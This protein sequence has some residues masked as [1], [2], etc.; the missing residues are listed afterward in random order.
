[1]N[2]SPSFIFDSRS[3]FYLDAPKSFNKENT[4][5]IFGSYFLPKIKLRLSGHYYL[6]SNYTYLANYYQLQQEAALFNF[7]RVSLEKIIKVGKNW[8][9]YIDL[10]L[11][12]KTGNVQ[13]NFPFIFTRQ[14][15]AY[16]GNLGFKNLNIAIGTELRYHTAYKADGYSPVL[17]KF[18]YQDSLTIKNLPDISFYLHFRI[19]SFK[20]YARVENLNTARNNNGFGFTNNNLAAPGYPTPGLQIRLGIYW[21]FVN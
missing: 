15:F 16:E 7:L 5:H 9:W 4:S 3:S 2:R 14:R 13:V 20:A 10:Q 18:F 21:S 19:R 17:S 11:Q 6:I 1:M 8:N 12:Q